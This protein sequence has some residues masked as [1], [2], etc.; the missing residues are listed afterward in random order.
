[1]PVLRLL[2][3]QADCWQPLQPLILRVDFDADR[4]QGGDTENRFR[5]VRAKDD[6]GANKL[7]HEFNA[8]NGHFHDDFRTVRQF[9][10]SFSTRL[11]ADAAQLRAGGH[12]VDRT[13][14]DEE[15]F[16]PA[17]IWIGWIHNCGG[18]V[19]STHS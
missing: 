2:L 10:D 19:S 3:L 5:V 7:T 13:C 18:Y 6:R 4:F 11:D 12:A 15:Q 8:C 16:F 9:V 17:T 14:V 1:M